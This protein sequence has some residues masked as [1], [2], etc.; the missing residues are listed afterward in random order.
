MSF[1]IAGT[2]GVVKFQKPVWAK[3]KTKDGSIKN[4]PFKVPTLD[5][6]GKKAAKN[7]KGFIVETIDNEAANQFTFTG[8]TIDSGLAFLIGEL[9][10]RDKTLYEP[11][12]TYYWKRDLPV[13]T[14]GGA[15]DFVSFLNINWGGLEANNGYIDGN[16]DA[17]DTI[18]VDINKT[19]GK[20]RP[21]AKLLK[22]GYVDMMRANQVGRSLD[23]ML[24]K[25]IRVQYNK[26]LDRVTM[27]GWSELSIPG[28]YN[29]T[30][31]QN[32]LVADNAGASSKLWPDKTPDEILEDVNEVLTSVWEAAEYDND[33]LPN[34]LNITPDRY[35]YI[36][37]RKVSDAGNISILKY[38]LENN[39]SSNQGVA[40]KIFPN[41]YGIGVGAGSTNRMV[42]YRNDEGKIRFHLPI[43]LTRAF[44][45]LDASKFSYLTPYYAFI[46]HN[47]FVYEETIAYRDGY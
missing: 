46:S 21:W 7:F 28:L 3:I 10:K 33:G 35:G 6:E 20:V 25:G 40:F 32:D 39:I 18:S 29:N 2:N 17:L 37:T 47:E 9:E 19:V 31:V 42:A 11:L 14:G 12:T 34:Q 27:E 5:D 26:E 1:N 30:N 44:T 8:K 45:S 38:I 43:P 15:V 13:K 16:T 41:R 23:E 4:L 36:V 24:T 22:I